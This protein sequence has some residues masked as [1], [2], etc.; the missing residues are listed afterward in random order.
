MREKKG[1]QASQTFVSLPTGNFAG[2]NSLDNV[3]ESL[4]S[5]EILLSIPLS[6]FSLLSLSL[7]T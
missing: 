5:Y 7:T 3:N 4:G 6:S 1:K 2:S